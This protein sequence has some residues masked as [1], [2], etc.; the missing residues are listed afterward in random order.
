MKRL[1]ELLSGGGGSYILP[2]LWMKGEEEA[3]IREEIEKIAE[4]GIREICAESRPH[5]DF[6]GPGWWQSMDVVLEEARRRNMRI[7]ILDDRKFPTGYANGAFEKHPE[8]A[9]VYLAE[10]H[11]DLIGPKKDAAV[12]IAPFLQPDG[13]LL[14]VLAV[15]RK[16]GATT[17]LEGDS[18]MDITDR[19][20]G[21]FVYLDIPEGRWRLFVIY[22]TQTGGG[23][24]N[25]MNLIDTRSVRVLID[26]V[27]EKH[28]DH[29]ADDFGKTIAG[30]FSDEPELGNSPGYDFQEYLGQKDKKLPWSRELKEELARIWG[31]GFLS[32]LPALWFDMG[33]ETVRIR[34]QYM[35]Q[36]TDL[37]YRCFSGQIG[38]WCEEHGVEYIGH[39]I[40]D[41]NAH[42]RMGC[43]I[44]HYF[45][46]MKGQ[47]MAGIDV[48]HFQIVPGFEDPVHQWLGWD[49][50]GEFFHYGL[51]KLGAS[52]A[53]I[54]P[55]K[56]GRSLC[57]IFGNYGWALG[58][59]GMKWLTDHMLSRGINHFT[60]HAFSMTFPDRD[61]PPH[62][63]A[64]GNN[65]QFPHFAKLMRYMNRMCHLYNGGIHKANAAILYHGEAEWGR[66]ERMAFQIP[67]RELM[68]RQLDYDVVPED[69]LEN[70]AVIRDGKLE[71]NGETYSCLIQPY[72]ENVPED[73][74]KAAVQA[75]KQGL[76]IYVIDALPIR[77]TKGNPLPE[78][79][80][81]SVRVIPLTQIA[82]EVK[83]LGACLKADGSHPH[84]RTYL[85]NQEGY[86]ICQLFNESPSEPIDT[87]LQY[88]GSQEAVLE[89]DAFT[90]TVRAWAAP[91]GTWSLHLEPGETRL[92]IPADQALLTDLGLTPEDPLTLKD[93]VTLTPEWRV[94][95]L[96]TP[97]GAAPQTLTIPAG[98]PLPNLNAPDRYPDYSG[99]YRYE[100]DI[101]ISEAQA[102]ARAIKLCLPAIGDTADLTVNQTFAGTILTTP[103]RADLTGLLVP[104]QNHIT[105]DTTTT[106]V[107]TLKDPVS[108]QI[109]LSTTGLTQPPILETYI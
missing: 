92:Y 52:A 15:K 32:S 33:E 3:V 61:C 109:Q 88:A 83:R 13:E 93:A 44:G 107:W 63:Y 38:A 45:K 56:K 90:N 49:M 91:D 5:P 7:W 26:E 17:D 27:Y 21:D 10:R 74:A 81:G 59:G 85:Y 84:L 78:D 60:P 69:I 89:Y 86:T 1:K 108:T 76:K 11:V 96:H 67:G 42:T 34:T 2:F 72:F 71:I 98:A 80:A 14:G 68:E 51:A 95:L 94:T 20:C 104:G 28:Y 9:K 6:A 101:Q 25:Y 75:A 65:P 102:R 100:A 19:V 4:C 41:K 70:G 12:L 53:H 99:T 58:V 50:D 24:P 39:V 97:S 77:T 73:Y 105:I 54:D 30:F 18:V 16:S 62:F 79:Y 46:E 87:T 40:E 43:S 55:A 22:T 64:R 8:L 36:V 57:E 37:V 29:Y 47:D 31:G 106:L 35:E 82:D 103:A 66:G 23:R 48:V